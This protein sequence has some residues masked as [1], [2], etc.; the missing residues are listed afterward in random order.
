MSVGANDVTH[1]TSRPHFRRDYARLLAAL[2]P[3]VHQVVML[4]V[5]DMGAPRLLQPL[6]AVTAWRGR[7]L[8][9]D[10]R[11]L[12]ARAGAVYVDIAGRA[13]PSFRRDPHRYLAAD[14]YHPDDAGYQLWARAVA[15]T[16]HALRPAGVPA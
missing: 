7:A 12:A 8:D 6:R 3:S 9:R 11:H 1:L 2:P 14:Q 5:P 4:G 15:D 10:V 13:G 16:L